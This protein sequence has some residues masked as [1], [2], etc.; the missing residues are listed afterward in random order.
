MVKKL[1]KL[2]HKT[3]RTFPF[4]KSFYSVISPDFLVMYYAHTILKKKYCPI[5]RFQTVINNVIIQ[6]V[7]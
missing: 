3:V 1:N 6:I 2:K 7:V 4:P 5:I